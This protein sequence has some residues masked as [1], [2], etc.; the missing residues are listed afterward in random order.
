MKDFVQPIKQYSNKGL[1]QKRT[2][3]SPVVE[4]YNKT[5]PQ[6]PKAL[7]DRVVELTQLPNSA[8]IL[9]I[10]CGPGT[11]TVTFAELDF[12]ILCLEPNPDFCAIARRNCA[13]YSKVEFQTTSFEEW[14][15]GAKRF[16]AVLAATSIHWIPPEIAYPKVANALQD[17]GSLILLWNVPAIPSYEVYQALQEVYQVHAPSLSQYKGKET[18]AAELRE[19]EQ[20]VISS[21]QFKDVVFEQTVWEVT[22]NVDEY[23]TLLSTFS[24]YLELDAKSRN[25][26][27]EGLQHKIDE[28]FAGHLQL[29]NLS[30]FHVAR[31]S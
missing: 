15:L 24:Q 19:L 13:K 2:W 29:L 28:N 3:Y 25:A 22:Y 20:I 7:V 1:E 4:A 5:R 30:A 21:C 27:F 10:G 8:T 16:D 23:L 17:N 14:N 26:L 18:H 6:Y 11:A 9:E 31:K 12:S